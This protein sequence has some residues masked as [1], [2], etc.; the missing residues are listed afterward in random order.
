MSDYVDLDPKADW[1]LSTQLTLKAARPSTTPITSKQMSR[2]PGYQIAARRGKNR[3]H[4]PSTAGKIML[5]PH[6]PELSA[7]SRCF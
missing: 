7:S 1:P 6:S 4:E 2:R 3:I 5:R